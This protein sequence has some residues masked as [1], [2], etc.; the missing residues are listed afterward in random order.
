MSE[1]IDW[2]GKHG[3]LRLSEDAGQQCNNGDKIDASMFRKEISCLRIEA[4]FLLNVCDKKLD[5]K[6]ILSSMES[7]L[8]RDLNGL[9]VG[10]GCCANTTGKSRWMPEHNGNAA[11]RGS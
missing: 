10:C 3:V 2:W 4:S 7:L 9:A 5:S 6:A 8:G 1:R 11:A